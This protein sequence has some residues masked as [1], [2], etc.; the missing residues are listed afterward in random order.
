MKVLCKLQQIT[1]EL[2]TCSVQ[3]YA[4]LYKYIAFS[5][6]TI[7]W[8]YQI[9]YVWRE[10]EYCKLLQLHMRYCILSGCSTLEARIISRVTNSKL[11]WKNAQFRVVLKYLAVLK[12]IWKV[13]ANYSY[14]SS[15]MVNV[16]NAY[17]VSVCFLY[18]STSAVKREKVIQHLE[19]FAWF[20]QE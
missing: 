13:Q 8:R 20:P 7:G 16:R 12:T 1:D 15:Y 6:K 11:L 9:I 17:I 5:I 4:G 18:H 3:F 19:S 10:S 14:L 2:Q